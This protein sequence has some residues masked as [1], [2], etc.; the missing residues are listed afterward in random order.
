MMTSS[1]RNF[2][3]HNVKGLFL[4]FVACLLSACDAQSPDSVEQNVRLAV[5]NTPKDS[6]LLDYLLA[7]FEASTGLQVHVHSS[8]DP[9]AQAMAGNADLVIAHYG[10]SGMEEFVSNGY[11][12]WP[13]MVFSNQAVIIGP[14]DDPAQLGQTS[15]LVDAFLAIA[16]SGQ[17]LIANNN[18]GITEL[19]ATITAQ[20]D[21]DR[22]QPWYQDTGVS[23]GKAIKA[24]EK[25]GAY[26]IW[27]AIPFLKFQSKHDSN[28]TILFSDDPLLQ[29]IMAI[30]RVSKTH[31]PEARRAAA[32]KL[33]DYLLNAETQAKILSFRVNGSDRQLWWPAARHN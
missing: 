12:S 8:E 11:G 2:L 14:K 22:Q 26:V 30:T 5:V 23:K 13:K 20:T 29:R 16:T 9:F 7:D 1:R 17:T 19:T 6:G 3:I 32:Q 10:K 28:M 25:S 33:E 27:G 18:E 4:L 24:A 31:F 15:S 21:L